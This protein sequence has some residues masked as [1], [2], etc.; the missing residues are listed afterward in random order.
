M[1]P[2]SSFEHQDEVI[3]VDY[4]AG[5]T[6]SI[7]NMLRRVGARVTV[8]REPREV[9]SARSLVLPGVGAFDEAMAALDRHDLVKP[10]QSATR[11]GA[12]VLG[13]CLGMQLMMESSEEGVLPGLGLIAGTCER[14]PSHVAGHRLLVP[15]MGWGHVRTPNP[16]DH[17]QPIFDTDRRYY[18]VH[19]YCVQPQQPRTIHGITDY[20]IE[21]VSAI[22]QDRL[23]GVQ[24]HPEKSGI[25]GLA[26]FRD[27]LETDTA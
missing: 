25:H 13:V 3:I 10:I 26:F 14:F 27:Y 2:Q 22:Q 21:F 1:T 18:F 4:G 16:S 12:A 24:F 8:S 11:S 20:G 19:S 7:E 5:N 9:A 6:G 23:I 15:H 17:L